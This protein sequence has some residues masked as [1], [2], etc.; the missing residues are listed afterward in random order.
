[1]RREKFDKPGLVFDQ[2][3][4]IHRLRKQNRSIKEDSNS[5]LKKHFRQLLY[6]FGCESVKENCN[7]SVFSCSCWHNSHGG[8]DDRGYYGDGFDDGGS[9]DGGGFDGCDFDCGDCGD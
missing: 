2:V 4:V 3:F 9:F 7:S 8:Y 6:H 5:L 1:M